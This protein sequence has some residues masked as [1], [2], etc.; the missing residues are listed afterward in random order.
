MSNMQVTLTV[1]LPV[2]IEKKPKHFVACCPVLDVWSQGDT[3]EKCQ[4]NIKEA[5]QLF[6][7]TCFEMGTLERVLKDSG[8]TTTKKVQREKSIKGFEHIDVP[9]PFVIDEH[10][11][12]CHA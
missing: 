12:K 7:T 6:L 3:F 8:F 10:L 11:A 2:R 1:R 9:L 5:I 4:H